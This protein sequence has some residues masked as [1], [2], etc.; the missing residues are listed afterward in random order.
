MAKA[1][2][3]ITQVIGAV[4]DVHFDADLPPILN[5]LE[6]QNQGRRLVLEVAQQLGE[7]TVRTVAMDISEG[8]V[9]GQEVTDTGAPISVPV[10]A[11][12]LGRIINVIGEP[13]DE[14]GPVKAEGMRAIHQ[15]APAFTDQSTEAAI[16]VTGIKV[17]DLL[18]PYAKG[19]KIGLFGGAGVGKTVLIMELINNV[20]KAHGGYSVF[21]GVGERTREGND[22]Y[23]EMIESK[24]NKD[25][26]EGSV[27]GSKCALVYG[28][29]NEPPGARARVGLTGLTVAEYF[30]DQGQ[31]V[32]FFVDNIF[33][34]TQAGSEVS[35]LLG[36]IPSAV[37]Y[38]PTLATDMGALQERITTTTKGSVTSVQAIY[39]PADD[40]TDP[41]PATSFAHLDATTVLSRDIA[42]KGI[43]PAVDPLDSTSRMLSPLIVGEEHYSIARQVQ[44]VLQRYKALQDIIAILGMDELSEEDKLTVARARKIERFLS[45]P[46]H[47]AEVFTGAAGKLVDLQDTI[48][49][50]KGLVEGKYNHLPEAAFYMVGT[51]DEAVE[52]GKK[53]AAEAA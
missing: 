48:S 40:L 27:E 38:Q 34:F 41:A 2:G 29:M 10:G 7:N 11:G 23:H 49:G 9:R 39:V 21:A 45:Q 20:A 22:L 42:A 37:G 12:L 46:F 30:R 15:E 14:A 18:A 3:H 6:T 13:V 43:Y 51:I 28:Q 19:G 5:A 36:R 47:V 50:F 52:K 24:V 35:A 17:V 32:L 31:D 44:Q 4:I 33:R 26:K 16:L 25:P 8:L 1:V 53:L